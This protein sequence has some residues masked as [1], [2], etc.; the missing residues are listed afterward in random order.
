MS[1]AAKMHE[2]VL[3]KRQVILRDNHPSNLL[4]MS[5]L[6]RI[7]ARQGQLAKATKMEEEVVEKRK[8]I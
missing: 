4:S 2:E 5:R 7:Y 8:V 1:E 6:P 3:A